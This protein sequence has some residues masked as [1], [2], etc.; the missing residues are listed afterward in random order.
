LVEADIG[1]IPIVADADPAVIAP[2][3]KVKSE[4][5]LTMKMSAGL[6]VIAT[7]IPS[8]E[9]VIEHGVNGFLARTRHDWDRCLDALRDPEL[10]RE[11]GEHA[12]RSVSAR[13]SMQA[14]AERFIAVCE[15]LLER[16]P[17]RALERSPD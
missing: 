4:N 12:R 10:R 14:Q 11:M 6:P 5:R 17:A 3:W 15:S 8:Y 1:V 7:P 2:A 16:Q 9:A 13:F